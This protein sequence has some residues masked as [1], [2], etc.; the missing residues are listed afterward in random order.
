MRKDSRGLR[1]PIRWL[2]GSSKFCAS[3][4]VIIGFAGY[5]WLKL[6]QSAV[7]SAPRL[8]HNGPP[9]RTLRT[10]D[11]LSRPD[12]QNE[13]GLAVRGSNCVWI[14]M[15]VIELTAIPVIW[16]FFLYNRLHSL[17][18]QKSKKY[19]Y[20]CSVSSSLLSYRYT[21]VIET[22]ALQPAS[23]R[24]GLLFF[25]IAS[26]QKERRADG[27]RPGSAGARV[28]N[29]HLSRLGSKP[30][31]IARLSLIFSLSLS[32]SNCASCV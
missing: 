30:T 17:V 19:I 21:A 13:Y 24:S 20:C 16:L 26:L 29:E 32:Y 22:T 14:N 1:H 9:R 11:F 5:D 6:I 8:P 3:I 23:L 15:L 18:Y 31:N 7:K 25:A 28:R 2:W 12:E 4:R 10:A 27:G